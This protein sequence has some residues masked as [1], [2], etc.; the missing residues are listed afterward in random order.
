M[1]D[2]EESTWSDLNIQ[3]TLLKLSDE[4]MLEKERYLHQG[5]SNLLDL[6]TTYRFKKIPGTPS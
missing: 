2:Q 6:G 1:E 3:E 4:Q 5:L